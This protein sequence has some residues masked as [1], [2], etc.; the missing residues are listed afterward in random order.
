M[1]P[2]IDWE[3]I[4]ARSIGGEWY[5]PVPDWIADLGLREGI[6]RTSNAWA[7]GLSGGNGVDRVPIDL[8][9]GRDCVGAIGEVVVAVLFGLPWDGLRFLARHDVG[10][11]QVKATAHDRAAHLIL[12][13]TDPIVDWY[14]AVRFLKDPGA[15]PMF[16]VMGAWRGVDRAGYWGTLPGQE[17]RPCFRIRF[18][19]LHPV[20]TTDGIRNRIIDAGGRVPERGRVDLDA[21]VDRSADVL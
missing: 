18:D 1:T 6:R 20:S 5:G 9:I 11:V 7:L 16:G 10:G 15:R 13:E 8:R 3:A 19:D 2:R 21:I 4:G 12:R 17:D 14:I